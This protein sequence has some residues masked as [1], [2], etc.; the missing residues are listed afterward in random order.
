L[1][2]WEPER[3]H[4]ERFELGALPTQLIPAEMENPRGHD[5]LFGLSTKVP[6][7]LKSVYDNLYLTL[8][9]PSRA[10]LPHHA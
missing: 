9:A 10:Y 4:A 8:G 6:W 5:S 7:L 1:K 3:E 2:V